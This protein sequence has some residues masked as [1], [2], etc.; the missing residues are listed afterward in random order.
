MKYSCVSCMHK[1]ILPFLNSVT[2]EIEANK[3]SV[4]LPQHV[5]SL[6]VVWLYTRN[7]FSAS[8]SIPVLVNLFI[9]RVYRFN[10]CFDLQILFVQMLILKCCSWLLQVTME[11]YIDKMADFFNTYPLLWCLYPVLIILPFVV[12]A[13][14]CINPKRNHVQVPSHV[15][16]PTV[17]FADRNTYV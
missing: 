11:Y 5:Y 4:G 2:E 14:F 15:Y 12:I 9:I 17:V 1:I 3:R 16:T 7:C 8:F 10:A 6:R 13:T